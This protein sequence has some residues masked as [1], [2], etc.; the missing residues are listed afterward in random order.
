MLV[1]FCSSRLKI[2]IVT[3]HCFGVLVTTP[4]I[5]GRVVVDVDRRE[6]VQVPEAGF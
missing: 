2:W 1:L 5:I 3:F 4:F 6:V